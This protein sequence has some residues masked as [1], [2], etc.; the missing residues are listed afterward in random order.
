MRK[1]YLFKYGISF[2]KDSGSINDH[3]DDLFGMVMLIASLILGILSTKF[4]KAEDSTLFEKNKEKVGSCHEKRTVFLYAIPWILFSLINTTIG[5]NVS[6]NII[7]SVP[8]SLYF[9]LSLL[10]LIGVAFG[11]LGGG[12]IADLFGRKLSLGFS[13]TLYGLSTALGGFA[14]NIEVS[15][16]VYLVNGL[17]WGI[18]WSLYGSVVWGDLVDG[19]NCVKRYSIGLIIFYFSLT[20]GLLFT[21]Q[22]SQIPVVWSALVGCSLI[23]LSN[24][25][26]FLAPELLSEDFRDKIRLKLHMNVVKKLDKKSRSQ[27]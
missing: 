18:L 17:N 24:I 10:Q 11:A 19:Q 16:F 1:I 13:L 20:L 7:Q 9:S 8:E 4:L 5:R 3:I 26:L 22:I 23:F 12:I 2:E 14:Q 27:G 21:S 25:P 15:Y 6:L